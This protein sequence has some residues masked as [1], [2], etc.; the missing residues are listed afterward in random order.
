MWH[1]TAKL[2]KP[3]KKKKS[4]KN[5]DSNDTVETESISTPDV[6]LKINDSEINDPVQKEMFSIDDDLDSEIVDD[7][8]T[9]QMES[10]VE[11]N[12]WKPTTLNL[13]D[14][15]DPIPESKSNERQQNSSI[16]E[17]PN[18]IKLSDGSVINKTNIEHVLPFI[19]NDPS[20][21]KLY[22][23]S[24]ILISKTKAFLNSRDSLPTIWQLKIFLKSSK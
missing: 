17:K 23:N 20:V 6:D 16:E 15:S 5:S 19:Y 8:I 21:I 4:K 12:D 10:N 2:P 13:E 14:Y 11:D 24:D 7:D 22:R 1:N 18:N 9:T 3:V